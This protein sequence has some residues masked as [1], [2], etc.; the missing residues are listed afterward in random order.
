M[1]KNFFMKKLPKIADL[2]EEAE[3]KDLILRLNKI[4]VTNVLRE[5]L[6]SIRLKMLTMIEDGNVPDRS[7]EDL[8]KEVISLAINKLSFSPYSLKPVINATGV[9]LHT[10][11][12]RAPLPEE[13]LKRI[14]MV[15]S[16]YSNLEF[17]LS[18]GE[19]GERYSHVR[20]LL[21]DITGAEDALV[22]NNNAAAVLL[23]LSAIAS[24]REVVISRGQLVEIGGSF[25]IPDVM[26]Q[27]GAKLVEVGTTN[28]TNIRDYEMAINE[29]TALL[30]KVHTSNFKQ[31]GFTSQVTDE[32][33]KAL[34]EKYNLP[35]MEDLGSGVLLDMR[36]FGF[37]EE[38]RVQDSVRAGMD[39]ITFS[40]DKLLGGPQAGIILGKAEYIS[41]IKRHPLNRAVRIDKLTLAALE[42]VLRL[43]KDG[44]WKHI[45]VLAMLMESIDDMEDR[46]QKL[47][48]GV[49][50]VLNEKGR[51]EII[52]DVTQAGGGSLPGVEIPTKCVGISVDG[53][54][55]EEMAK[56]LRQVS[57]PVVARVKK[58][59]LL[60]DLRT[61]SEKEIEKIVEMVGKAIWAI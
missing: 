4:Y 60:F 9:V 40:G 12:G 3:I 1:D 14:Q 43:Y 2:L 37:S 41:V 28:K 45:P 10:N 55:P 7:E 31:I 32:E 42:A 22:V 23:C 19:R 39:L 58:D 34:W 47:A 26:A 36:S 27:S 15:A 59:K 49:K 54:S 6:E 44:R 21:C 56:R 52:N 17:D 46:A 5:S 24:G 29:N 50:E 38:P 48:E 25:R 11:L 16:G 53:I 35:V 30:L 57:F 33:L 61:I 18:I 20:E 13:A 51:V 8:K